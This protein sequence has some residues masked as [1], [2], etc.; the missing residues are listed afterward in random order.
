MN[1]AIILSGGVG[2]RM[3][4]NIP[5]QYLLVNEKPIIN[6]SI[7]K[8]LANPSIDE[9]VIAIADE[10]CQFVIEHI[11]SLM[12][13]KNIYFSHA[14]ITRQHSIYNA[15]KVIKQKGHA[16]HDIVII[17][18]AARPLVNMDLINK[19]ITECGKNDGI[20]PVIP[21]KD[22]VYLSKDGK[23]IDTLLN[24]SQL[25]AGQAPEAFV[26]G[27]YWKAHESMT[28]E[29]I[30]AITGST[31]LAYK[32]GL[33][34]QLIKGDPLNFKITTSEDLVNFENIINR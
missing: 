9:I 21:V 24:R 18:D 15:L 27:P 6:Y 30:S 20:M 5:K 16:D 8:F 14:G 7:E 25:W 17:H 22:T 31:E 33:R 19:C 12:P 29:D 1:I 2:T 10:W 13:T 4:T 32:A 23:N 28:E 11:E 3:N 26:L 34:I